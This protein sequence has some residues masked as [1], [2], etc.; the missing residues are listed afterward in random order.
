MNSL[1]QSTQKSNTS[2]Y[3]Q[4]LTENKQTISRKLRDLAGS[5]VRVNSLGR[6][7]KKSNISVRGGTSAERNCPRKM[8]NNLTRKT[9]RKTREKKIRKTIRNATE[10]VLAP[11]RPLKIFHRH[12]STN[13]KSFSPPKICT[14]NVFFHREALQG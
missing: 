13:F 8:F 1:G 2:E 10:K 6:S 5:K 4:N 3:W 7:A 12:F 9:V 11:L 14:K